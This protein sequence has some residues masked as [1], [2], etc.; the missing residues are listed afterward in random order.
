MFE[1]YICLATTLDS[2]RFMN[3]N[4]VFPT[5]PPTM[6]MQPQL[7]P[8]PST[9]DAPCDCCSKPEVKLSE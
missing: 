3:M 7:A 2:Q 8:V 1:D 5:Q 9:V 4:V 6:G